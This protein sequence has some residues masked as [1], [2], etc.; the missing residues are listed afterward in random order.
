MA[1]PNPS[2]PAKVD[3][4]GDVK[5]DRPANVVFTSMAGMGADEHD[6]HPPGAT[7]QSVEAGHEPDRFNVKPILYI[8]ALVAVTVLVAFGVITAIFATVVGDA[9]PDAN[10]SAQSAAIA[11]Q[12]LDDRMARISSSDPNAPVNQPRLE[13]M[14]Q[15]ANTPGDPPYYRS[16]LPVKRDGQT[17][18]IY[19]QDLRPGDFIDP[20]LHRKILIETGYVDKDKGIAFVPI[21]D[22]MAML[23]GRKMLPTRQADAAKDVDTVTHT[24]ISTDRA[25]LSNAGRGGPSMPAAVKKDGKA[26]DGHKPKDH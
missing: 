16:K 13:Y 15:V 11:S 6:T 22:A 19:P 23:I 5:S 3:A 26:A 25:K 7:A 4:R 9:E 21:A 24:V 2:D 20:T 17:Y 1:N 8:P 12:P 18:E 10:T 14:K